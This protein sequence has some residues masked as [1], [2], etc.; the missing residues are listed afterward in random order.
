M[1]SPALTSYNLGVL[2][3][4][5]LLAAISRADMMLKLIFLLGVI[6]RK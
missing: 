3:M 6:K 1:Q 2:T 5:A 4:Q